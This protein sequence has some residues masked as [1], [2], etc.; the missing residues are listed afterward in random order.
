MKLSLSP[1]CL[2]SSASAEKSYRLEPGR[3]LRLRRVQEKGYVSMAGCRND[4][5]GHPISRN[6]G[7]VL[8][9]EHSHV[10]GLKCRRGSSVRRQT[11]LAPVPSNGNRGPEIQG[12]EVMRL[13]TL[14]DLNKLQAQDMYHPS[15]PHRELPRKN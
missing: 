2:K 13:I 5:T 6:R 11:G 10:G 7:D 8:G 1:R 12:G 9:E 14:E 4:L 3:P 15:G